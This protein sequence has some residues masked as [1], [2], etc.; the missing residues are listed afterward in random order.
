M[1]IQVPKAI[2]FDMDGTLVDNI[3]F[4]Q[5]AWLRFLAARR[6]HIRVEEFRAQNHGTITEM[7]RRFFPEIHDAEVIHLLGQEKEQTYR[8]LYGPH[9]RAMDGLVEFLESLQKMG[10]EAHLATMGD[11]PNIDF[12]FERLGLGSYF[13]STTGGEMVSKGKPDPEIFVKSMEKAGLLPEQCWVIEDSK[14]G[15]LAGKAAGC[16]VI[17]IATSHGS[18]ELNAFGADGTVKDFFELLGYFGA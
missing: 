12:V 15:I 13:K 7:I 10:I 14:G 11:Q 2:L 4:H 6:V 8:D 5:E 16:K 1:Q 17:G 18:E 9:I 3:P